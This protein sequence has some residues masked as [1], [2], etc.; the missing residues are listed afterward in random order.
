MIF[1][2]HKYLIEKVKKNSV[3]ILQA[4]L[5]LSFLKELIEKIIRKRLIILTETIHFFLNV[6][7][8]CTQFKPPF[9][10]MHQ[11]FFLSNSTHNFACKNSFKN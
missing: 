9:F 2:C 10:L 4:K 3:E 5:C 1:F 11:F 7:F 8:Y 6:S